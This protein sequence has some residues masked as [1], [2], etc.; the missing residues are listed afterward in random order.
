MPRKVSRIGARIKALR[1]RYGWSQELLAMKSG[2]KRARIAN[3]ETGQRQQ[4]RADAL[5]KLARA[6][7]VAVEELYEAAGYQVDREVPRHVET[8]EEILE[9]LRLAQPESI[10]VY[11]DFHAGQEHAE[12]IEYIYRSPSRGVK[13]NIEAYNVHGYCMEP[14]IN[15]G[16]IVVVDHDLPGEAGDIVLCLVND[17]V[18]VG[19][20]R[21]EKDELWLQNNEEK[22]RLAD[23][24]ASAVVI[25]VI[26]RLK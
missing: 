19:R 15:D 20:L 6:F 8:P 22:I 12:P 23:F 16:N 1:E 11:R 17:E 21:L 26:K 3:W 9:R 14:E 2:L 18:I 4:P 25:E 13:G 5:M 10:P 7:H 24:Q